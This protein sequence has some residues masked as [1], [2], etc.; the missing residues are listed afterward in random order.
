[1]FNKDLKL[2]NK[3]ISTETLL[4]L[5]SSTLFFLFSKILNIG[6]TDN[7]ILSIILFSFVVFFGLPHGALDTLIAKKFKIY[8]NLYEFLVFN[9]IYIL[10]A[11]F[12]FLIWQFLPIL[13]L[14]IFLIISGFHFSE[15]WSS[16]KIQKIKK[17]ALGFSVINLPILFNKE[18][19]EN[20]YYY[21]TN[22]NYVF[23]FS[24]IQIVFSFLNLLFLVYLIISNS[25]PA[26]T[27]LQSLIIIFSAYILN[28]LLF[29][30]SYFCFF[31]SY[32]NFEEAKGVLKNIS[33]VKIRLVALT[34]TILSLAIGLIVF[35]LFYSDF[36]LKN[37][38][39]LI[40]I[41]LAALTVPHMLLRIL[42][43]QK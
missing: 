34:N 43:K 36:N 2:N 41:G 16:L 17:L 12:I 33:K 38:T 26:N 25:F 37:I 30:I 1:M 32:K 4:F 31:H 19:V 23:T 35:F 3:K 22:S 10:V 6:I 5:T 21:I 27:L 13:S 20:I 8:N 24:S 42:I 14:S 9:I 28:P 15:D 11:I 39:S 29:F 7:N 18:S 40:F